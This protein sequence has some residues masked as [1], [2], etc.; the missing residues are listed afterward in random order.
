MLL[1]TLSVVVSLLPAASVHADCWVEYSQKMH[2]MLNSMGYSAP[3][4][5][6]SFSSMEECQ[7]TLRSIMSRPEY[8]GDAYMGG[9]TCH[10]DGAG[11]AGG[12]SS[13]PS[14]GS[15]EQ[16]IVATAMNAFFGALFKAMDAPSGPSAEELRA[17]AQR[18][19]DGLE[20]VRKES[21]KRVAD[22]NFASAKKDALGLMGGRAA[23]GPAPAS[24]SSAPDG[25]CVGDGGV[26]SLLRASGGITDAE[27]VRV[28][29]RRARI[30]ELARRRPRA[31]EEE[32]ELAR[33]EAERNALWKKAA[34]TP[35][36]GQ[37][38]RDR[39]RIALPH[40]GSSAASADLD[41]VLRAREGVSGPAAPPYLAPVM[42]TSAATYGATMVVEQSADAL[43]SKFGERAV[44]FGDAYAVGGVAM[45]FKDGTPEAATQPAAN[46]ALGKI[47]G[48]GL[49]GA[50]AQGVGA[51]TTAVFR[52]SWDHF[53]EEADKVVP[54]ALGEGGA[55]GFWKDMKAEATTGQRC[56][57]EYLGL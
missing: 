26:P 16:Q 8:S 52:K 49:A 7:A 17:E 47:P 25:A 10:C 57:F 41:A 4:R 5:A 33:L 50:T 15:F 45:A 6:S 28:R 27:W 22:R 19:W 29:E 40:D 51:V 20:K 43:V 9:S 21:E 12:G 39:L 42:G 32:S 35:G 13:V 11:S 31:P 2:G 48:A 56:V 1:G 30:D 38:D 36:L 3:Q 24:P 23:A 55:E 34:Q 44:G 37:A 18:K 46:W 54:G 14:G 53:V